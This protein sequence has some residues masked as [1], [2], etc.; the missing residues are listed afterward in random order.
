MLMPR[1]RLVFIAV[2]ALLALGAT[3]AVALTDEPSAPTEVRKERPQAQRISRDLAAAFAVLRSPR[4]TADVLPQTGRAALLSEEPNQTGENGILS[5]FAAEATEGTRLYV[6]PGAGTLCVL[7]VADKSSGG[8]CGQT[9]DTV[10]GRWWHLSGGTALGIAAGK[11]LLYGL[12][13]D[14]IAQVSVTTGTAPSKSI[15]PQRNVW[16]TLVSAGETVTVQAGGNRY[17]LDIP[18][19]P[20][21]LP[22][23]SPAR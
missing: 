19:P 8:G 2:F 18:P 3:A 11:L 9:R 7:V 23:R 20:P 21:P 1:H 13:P 15:T 10:S 22:T 4:E 14:N 5:R 16:W 17:T 12:A 6:V